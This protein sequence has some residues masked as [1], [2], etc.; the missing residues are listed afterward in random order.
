MTGQSSAVKRPALTKCPNSSYGFVER[1]QS[2]LQAH[3]ASRVSK[4][5]VDRERGKVENQQ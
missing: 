3:H 2:I 5:V 1:L 4:L